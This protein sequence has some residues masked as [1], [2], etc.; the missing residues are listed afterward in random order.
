MAT[1][2]ILVAGA[3]ILIA[4]CERPERE[5]PPASAVA[6]AEERSTDA[7]PLWRSEPRAVLDD[8]A[9]WDTT[10]RSAPS[11]DSARNLDPVLPADSPG[12]H[13][14]AEVPDSLFGI[15]ETWEDIGEAS[16]WETDSAAFPHLP[17]GGRVAGPSVLRAQVLLDR[18]GFSPGVLDGRWGGNVERAVF[19]FQRREGFRPT[20]WLDAATLNRLRSLAGDAP[21]ITTRTL[22][23]EDLEGP[24]TDVPDDVEQQANLDC[25]CHEGPSEKIAERVH[26][27][28]DMLRALNP[29]FDWEG[30]A[31]GDSI[32]VPQ[33][34]RAGS[35]APGPSADVADDSAQP[36]APTRA[37][38]AVAS[39]ADAV[40]KIVISDRGR[41]LHAYDRSGRLLF[42]FPATLG[43]EYN[44]SPQGTLE[45]TSVTRDP[46][47][48]YQPELLEG[49]DPDDPSVRLP[50]GPN[51]PVG[52]VWIALSR[53]HY[54]IHGTRAP[55]TIGYVTSSGCVR[56]TNWDA[57]LLA[58]HVGP[59]TVVEF[60]DPRTEAADSAR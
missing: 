26:T 13:Q 42:H 29:G 33:V 56:L 40:T 22:T 2:I 12:V 16:T 46:W 53:E 21:A 1:R 57:E 20:G 11:I 47:F 17:L 7:A 32:R 8:R 45:V 49:A 18:A 10:W 31:G 50:P 39:S 48:H 44:P 58:R 24:F 14:P 60:R 25:L 38:S 15:P 6:P 55:E 5:A 30:A 9:R 59:G 19:W 43:S 34:E 23:A 28:P 35:Q 54:G 4:A 36:A 27:T 3:T 37:D 41:Y 51:S 52:T